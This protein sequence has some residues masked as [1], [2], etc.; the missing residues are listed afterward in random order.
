MNKIIIR[1]ILSLLL[2]EGLQAEIIYESGDL[3]EFV[4]GSSP[5]TAYDNYVSHISEG[6]ADPGYND[7]GPDWLDVQTDGFGN[8]RI[9]PAGSQ[10]LL[11][12]RSIFTHL[13]RGEI[14]TADQLLTD[15]LSTFHYSLVQFTDTTYART[16]YML[17][18]NL[19]YSYFDPNQPGITGDEVS[20]SFANGWGLYILNPAAARQQLIVEIPHP[21]DDFI[22]PYVGTQLFRQTDALA[23]M[24][25]GAGRE[26]K[27]TGSG[28][29]SN[30]KSLSDPSR[31][32]NSVF[33]IYHE[34]LSDSLMQTG[35]H[36]PLVLHMHSFDDNSSHAGFRSIVLSGGWDAGYANKPIRDVT[37]SHLDFVNFTAEIPVPENTFGIHE[38]VMIDD[39][40]QVHYNGSFYYYGETQNYSIPHTYTLLGPNT[41]VQ[42]NYLRQFFDNR[43]VYEPWVQ[44]ELHEKPQLFQ[45][46]DMPLTELYAGSYPT[47]YQ[48]FQILLDYYQPFIDAAEA[49]LVNWESVPDTTAP[50]Q[51][52]NLR[53]TYDGYH[54]VTLEWDPT[55]DTNFRTYQ[56]FYDTLSVDEASPYWD[57]ENDGNL[58]DMLQINTTVLGLDGEADYLFR[59]RGVD[60][61]DNAGELSTATT[62][63]I[64]GHQSHTIIENFDD[65]EVVLGSFEDQDI[66]PD[67]WA[68]STTH[69]FMESPYALKL[70]GNTWKT[71][72]IQPAA[73]DS[74]TVWRISCYTLY[75][76]EIQGFGVQDSAHTLMY[77]FNGSQL[78]DIEDWVPVY[79]GSMPIRNWNIYELPLADDWYAWYD[80]YP[81]ISGLIFV[82]DADEDDSSVAYFDE[83]LD[84]TPVLSI[85]PQVEITYEMGNLYRKQDGSRNVDVAFSSNVTDPD[86][87]EFEYYWNFGDGETSSEANPTHT[88]IVEDDHPYTVLL[89]VSDSSDLWGRATVQIE[90]DSG[91][92]SFPLRMNFTGDIMLARH[93]EDNGGIIETSG[94]E[95]IFDPT[96]PW[97]GD[98][99][100]I[101]VSNLE[102]PLTTGGTP[103]PTKSIVFRGNPNNV[104][105]LVHAGI[106]V[107]TLAN[108]H[109]I[110][111]GLYGLQSTQNVL[112]NHN[113]LYSGAGENSQEAYEPLFYSAKGLSIAFLANSDRTG[114]YNNAQPYLNSGYNKPGFAYLT[115]YYLL[116]QIEAVQADADL[117]IMEMHAGSEYSTGPGSNYDNFFTGDGLDPQTYQAP[118]EDNRNMDIPD[119][120]DEDE[121]YSPYLD[122]PHMWDRQIRHFAIDS[123]A[124]LVVVHHPHIIQGFEV[125]NG[126]LI[127]HS[128]GNFV[129]DLSYEETFPSVI[130]NAEADDTGFTAYSATP[131]FIDHYIP[132]R[133]EGELGLYILDH[134]ADKSRELETYLYIDRDSVAAEVVMDTLNML[135]TDVISRKPMD[136]SPSID[137]W[138]SNPLKVHSTGNPA[139]IQPPEGG[140]N[141]QFRLGKE[142]I[143][144][145]NMEAEGS[146]QWNLNSGDEWLDTTIA[147]RGTR[148]VTHRRLP[149]SGDNIVTNLQNRIKI[150][151]D[152]D[153]SLQGYIK[154]Q[155]GSNVTIEVRY[156]HNRSSGSQLVTHD[157]GSHVDGT[158]DWTYYYQDTDP[159]SSAR[160]FDIRLNSD[161]PVS[162]EARSWFDDVS[163]IEWTDWQELSEEQIITNPNEYYYV[164]LRSDA[165]ISQGSLDFIERVYAAGEP[166][167]ADFSADITSALSPA[168]IRFT[169][170]S[171]GFVGWWQ[172]DFG[173]GESSMEQNPV[174]YYSGWGDYDVSL[175]VLDYAGNPVT[176]TKF[177]YIHM[178]SEY[179]PGDMNF[180][181][182]TNILD[183]VLMVNI[184][185]DIVDPTPLQEEVGDL[186]QDGI[187]NILDVIILINVILSD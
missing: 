86:S 174:H 162:G 145:G 85:S 137:G 78:L 55:E 32:A 75:E 124:D 69:T 56:I 72:S 173:D 133:A 4:G 156:Y 172:W 183:I 43:S 7:Y 57:V 154:T 36:S 80:Y 66:E 158:T 111:Y 138:V 63:T 186:N 28:S 94:V 24:I 45:D 165:Q 19:D 76:G 159:P 114:Q 73:V 13:L 38:P 140:G 33:Q 182:A 115:P 14:N 118:D 21:C 144:Y 15:S 79:Q 168:Q 98:A 65:G 91:D 101:S 100:D 135:I 11:Y 117:I 71:E 27:W 116:Q 99:A 51:V 103:H 164:Q 1:L 113:I 49:Y 160:Y 129:F 54:Y 106:D 52:Q 61:F 167:E 34:V 89:Q 64:P 153:Y 148:S 48:N 44:C 178:L 90:V 143:W 142:R 74:G 166:V 112:N 123:G 130:L 134:L 152:I 88:F 35:P 146:T 121:N 120:S 46:M 58:L 105:G 92:S 5:G 68:L 59:V 147:Y 41:G 128:L 70:Y 177:A 22:A 149:N 96:L 8:Y 17:R 29:Y 132:Q 136:L 2:F 50:A 179:L 107:V 37:D 62:D 184:I 151:A 125:Y 81:T 3:Q 104:N 60:Y 25:S 171:T 20:G 23:M 83:V 31:N 26:V 16:Y 181:N 12:W 97:L 176:E 175:T 127:A 122:I 155:N 67:H 18:E 170:E 77:S 163:L 93:F 87:D 108:N 102:C 39:Y 110:D 109:T 42:M 9:I 139:A 119:F 10:T 169:D 95:S 185:I 187:L 141:W 126:K 40:Y 82:N 84:I 180:D 161:M 47:S 6:L 150:D 53:S 131:V 30:N 157:V